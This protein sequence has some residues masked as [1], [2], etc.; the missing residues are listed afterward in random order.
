MKPFYCF[1]VVTYVTN[2]T[3]GLLGN[4]LV[5]IYLYDSLRSTHK[6]NKSLSSILLNLAAADILT[7]IFGIIKVLLEYDVIVHP[8]G[9]LGDFVCKAVTSGTL[10][11]SFTNVSVLTVVLLGWERYRAVTE[12]KSK[13]AS[14]D[15]D[16]IYIKYILGSFWLVGPAMY[17]PFIPFQF[18]DV[19][20]GCYER[21][22]NNAAKYGIPLMD[23]IIFFVI[24]ST[25]FVYAYTKI[26]LTL[27]KPSKDMSER[28]QK[29]FSYRKVRRKLTM[30]AMLIVG[31]FFLCWSGAYIIY[32][33]EVIG[34]IESAPLDTAYEIMVIFAYFASTS[35]PIIYSFRSKHFRNKIKE[36]LRETPFQRC[37][38]QVSSCC[39]VRT[40]EP[41]N[42]YVIRKTDAVEDEDQVN[43]SPG[44]QKETHGVKGRYLTE[45]T[46]E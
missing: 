23:I 46:T 18:Y 26:V 10:L 11:W 41:A 27:K 15:V 17:S 4:I 7:E 24:P 21:F 34:D 6:F 28:R 9:T 31:G 13:V 33:V 43:D 3:V 44:I 20:E 36:M 30:T 32:T 5:I 16:A 25:F 37:F 2:F 19:K 42:A 38:S 1:L 12:F 45:S 14:S 22:P 29:Q 39:P 40:V 8:E 35:H